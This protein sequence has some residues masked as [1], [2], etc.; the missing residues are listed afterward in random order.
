MAKSHPGQVRH[1]APARPGHYRCLVLTLEGQFVRLVPLD[2]G[3]CAALLAAA[4]EDRRSYQFT[5]VPRNAIEMRMFIHLATVEAERGTTIPFATVDARTGRL[6]G[7]TRF[8][9]IER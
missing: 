1:R 5:I 7:S 9:N 8:L 4:D 6:V 2:L 3:H